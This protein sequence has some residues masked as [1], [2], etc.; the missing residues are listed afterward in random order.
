MRHE[1]TIFCVHDAVDSIMHTQAL[2]SWG[3]QNLSQND[4]NQLATR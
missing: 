2:E 3:M 4:P 1:G